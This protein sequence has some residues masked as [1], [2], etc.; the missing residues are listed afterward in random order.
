M[1]TMPK[2]PV[3]PETKEEIDAFFKKV[4]ENDA[5]EVKLELYFTQAEIDQMCDFER[6]RVSNLKRNYDM[7][8]ELG[9]KIC[10]VTS[11]SNF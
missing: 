5:K 8:K 10:S 11:H 3:L 1:A 2:F 9:K 7:M 4:D 6:K